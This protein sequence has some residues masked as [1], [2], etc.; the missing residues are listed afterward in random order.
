MGGVDLQPPREMTVTQADYALRTSLEVREGDATETDRTFYDTFDGLVRDD[1]CSVVHERGRLALVDSDTGQER[2]AMP[3]PQPSQPLL[4]LGL[5]PGPLRD[6]LVP[7]VDVRALLPLVRVYSRTRALHVL[8]GEQK[9]VVRMALEEPALVS[10]SG[11][12]APL[13][14]RVRLTAVRG[15]DEELESVRARLQDELGFEPAGEPVVDEAVRAA[16]GVPGGTSS[17]IEVTM[18]SG[19]RADAAATA[20]LRRLLDVI[21][22]NLDGTLADVDAEF[23][24][25][26]RVSVRRSRSVQR[27]L[28]HV[29]PPA[30]LAHFRSE[31]RWLQQATGDARDLDV[32]VLEFDSMRAIVPDEMRAALEPLLSVLRGRRLTARREMVWAL[33]SERTSRLLQDWAA[34]LEELVARPL[35]ERPD[36]PRPID[37]L[38]GERIRKVYRRMVKMGREIDSA[39]PP[40]AYHELRKRGKEL[41]YLLELFGAPLYPSV[42]VKPMIRALKSLQDVLG[43]HQDREIQVATLRSLSN[44]VSALPGAPAALMAMGVLVT[45]LGEDEQAARDEFSE[46]FAAF[47]SK[48]ERRLVEETFA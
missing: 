23:L 13:R 31:F 28:K 45:R 38:A 42:V 16:G 47:A 8:N 37:E 32:Y 33:R 5:D 7:I 18:S 11:T 6:A 24:H 43:R 48:A 1:G 19:Q 25:D 46:R 40:E 35:D 14:P 20:V 34:F 26:L 4:A 17:K 27:E 9:T 41:R 29:F 39:S 22:A 3:A 21:E 30:E 2:A 36:A 44:E 12:R 10:A 15:Y